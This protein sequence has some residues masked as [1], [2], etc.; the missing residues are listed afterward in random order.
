MNTG[1]EYRNCQTRSTCVPFS[2]QMIGKTH[3]QGWGYNSSDIDDHAVFKA[4][5]DADALGDQQRGRPGEKA[6][7]AHGLEELK[8]IS[9]IVRLR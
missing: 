1:A 9:M 5:G 6:I 4:L 2:L 7:K 3:N 8:R